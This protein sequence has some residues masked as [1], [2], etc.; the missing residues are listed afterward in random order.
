MWAPEWRCPEVLWCSVCDCGLASEASTGKRSLPFP[1]QCLQHPLLLDALQAP[2]QKIDLQ[3]LLA[4]LALQ[5]GDAAFRPA[6]LAVARKDIA[7][8]LTELPPPAVQHVGVHLQRPRRLAHGY[9]L[10]QPPYS[11]QFELLGELPTRQSHDSIL[12]SMK[13]ES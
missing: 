4:D 12:H 11:G 6:L 9:P 10:F 7:R 5:L 13:I 2:L 8:S 3:R 1:S